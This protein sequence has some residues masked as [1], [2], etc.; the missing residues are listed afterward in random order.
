MPF[1]N[2]IKKTK[3]KSFK[4]SSFKNN[5]PKVE[6]LSKINKENCENFKGKLLIR[7][8]YEVMIALEKL[9]SNFDFS[10]SDSHV[11][12]L[13]LIGKNL[14]S[15][16][17]NIGNLESLTHLYLNVNHLTSLPNSFGNLKSLSVLS[18]AGNELSVLPESFGNLT[19]LKTLY[20]FSN[21]LESLPE[22]FGNLSKTK[23]ILLYSNKLKSLPESIGKLKSLQEL[24]LQDNNITVLPD[25]IGDLDSIQILKLH[26]NF[27]LS[28]LPSSIIKL[29]FTIRELWI[30]RS[31]V[32]NLPNILDTFK[33]ALRPW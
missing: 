24:E 8:E 12:T 4:T 11:V 5:S 33:S 20:L 18:L 17:E 19:E 21:Q 27:K 15:L 14:T 31:L 25:T 23:I 9:S 22:S 2:N 6:S 26:A 16:P 30:N 29:N 3:D 1:W 7:P 32:L 28:S 10:V 13:R